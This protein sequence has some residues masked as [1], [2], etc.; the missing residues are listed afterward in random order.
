MI[1]NAQIKLYILVLDS[2]TFKYQLLTKTPYIPDVPTFNVYEHI[3][4][5]DFLTN[6]VKIYCI[7]ENKDLDIVLN[8]KL[9]DVDIDEYVNISYLTFINFP[10][11]LLEAYL[12]N[13]NDIHNF[14][15]LS[16]LKKI[17]S[18]V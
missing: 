8:F 12:I 7:P 15:N 16:S 13:I 4:I 1:Q 9:I 3:D 6:N 2:K 11:T 5:E 18:L 10:V 14:P 17:L